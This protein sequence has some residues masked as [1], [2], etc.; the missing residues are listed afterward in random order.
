[1]SWWPCEWP[2]SKVWYTRVWEP[3]FASSHNKDDMCVPTSP[4]VS[5]HTVRFGIPAH[6]CNN[7][8]V[9]ITLYAGFLTLFTTRAW[10]ITI[11]RFCFPFDESSM[12]M[13]CQPNVKYISVKGKINTHI[14]QI[15]NLFLV[16]ENLM[17]ARSQDLL[18][19]NNSTYDP[20]LSSHSHYIF[21]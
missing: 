1:M 13:H 20:Y 6:M 4:Y 19:R 10:S 5:C 14:H 11:A 7:S 9:A 8:Q 21:V 3:Q 12:V 15:H 17:D 16:I 18:S 2:C